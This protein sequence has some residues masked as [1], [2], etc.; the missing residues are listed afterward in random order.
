[1]AGS[2][3]RRIL[4]KAAAVKLIESGSI[5]DTIEAAWAVQRPELDLELVC[6]LLRLDGVNQQQKSRGE[7]ISRAVGLS[8]SD[9]YLLLALRRS[10]KPYEMRPTDLFRALLVTSAAVT[11]RVAKLQDEGFILR[12]SASDDGRSE[13]VRLTAKGLAT[14]DRGIAEIA[15]DVA[16]TKA[17]S[18]LTRAELAVLDHC[19]RKLLLAGAKKPSGR[20]PRAKGRSVS[21]RSGR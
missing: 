13:L 1:M 19:L 21:D 5:Y 11:K 16:Y 3:A 14:A 7:E 8:L 18:G 6:T 17:E 12:V 4:S 15:R 2:S 10:G 20:R 9:L